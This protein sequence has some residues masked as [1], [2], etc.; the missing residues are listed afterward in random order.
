MKGFSGQ[1][2][3]YFCSAM[4]LK[5]SDLIGQQYWSVKKDSPLSTSS[6]LSERDNRLRIQFEQPLAAGCGG[7]LLS[8]R[9]VGVLLSDP[10]GASL[11]E[12]MCHRFAPTLFHHRG[13]IRIQTSSG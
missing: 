6:D 12:G 5:A 8:S 1:V 2:R 4:E 9:R 10:H 11:S 3:K 13:L 7:E